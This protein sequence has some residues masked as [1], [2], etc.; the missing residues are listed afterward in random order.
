[1]L[2]TDVIKH[3]CD[4]KIPRQALGSSQLHVVQTDGKLEMRQGAL[5]S[6]PLMLAE[7]SEIRT[8]DTNVHQLLGGTWGRPGC[9]MGPVTP[10]V[11][12]APAPCWLQAPLSFGGSCSR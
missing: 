2:Q 8:A 10:Q 3:R 5:L 6:T 4:L 12:P 7:Q 9:G 1:M 11:V